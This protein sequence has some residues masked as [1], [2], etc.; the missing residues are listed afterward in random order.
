V[1]ELQ[2][3]EE[4][5]LQLMLQRPVVALRGDRF[6]I[7]RPSPP[8]TI[9]GGQVLDP[10]PKRRH[11]RFNETRLDELAQLLVGTPEEILHQA[12]KKLGPASLKDIIAASGLAP[13]TAQASASSLMDKGALVALNGA[14][15]VIT[16]NELEISSGKITKALAAF[17]Q[18]SPLR[19]GMPRE[20]LKSQL[21]MPGEVFDAIIQRLASAG[22]L[23]ESGAKLKLAGHTVVF[24]DSQKKQIDGLLGLFAAEPYSPPTRKVCLEIV[25]ESLL[26]ALLETGR[27]FQVNEDILFQPEAYQAMRAAVIDH[28][29]AQGEITL[30]ELR[31]KFDTSRKYAVAVLEHLDQTGI[32]LR[33]GDIRVLRR[34]NP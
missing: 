29:K 18:Q 25:E 22:T 28:I 4:A 23:E 15:R 8:S 27:L 30:A 21:G 5:F 26:N 16:E 12:A 10:H 24:T 19:A 17:H 33:R 9:G 7:R 13:E 1:D 14:N 31:D 3:G 6:I 2:P 11:K 20:Q 32:T 34:P